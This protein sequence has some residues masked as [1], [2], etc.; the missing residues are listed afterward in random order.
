MFSDQPIYLEPI[1]SSFLIS[2][3]AFIVKT[4]SLIFFFRYCYLIPFTF[5]RAAPVFIS[6]SNFFVSLWRY[7]SL[8]NLILSINFPHKLD[9]WLSSVPWLPSFQTKKVLTELLKIGF[10]SYLPT[11]LPTYILKTIVASAIWPS[12]TAKIFFHS[13]VQSNNFSNFQTEL[14]GNN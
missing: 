14:F 6:V 10:D 2:L 1:S 11:Y 8:F 13:K 5:N 12:S 7:F 4:V 3:K 9:S